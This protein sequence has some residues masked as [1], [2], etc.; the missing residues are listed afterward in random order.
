MIQKLEYD[1]VKEKVQSYAM[2]YLGRRHAAGME[3]QQDMKRIQRLLEE[4]QEARAVIAHGASVPIPSLEGLE[5]IMDLLGKGYSLDVAE[6]TCIAQFLESTQ[7]LKKFMIKRLPVAPRVSGYAQALETLDGLLDEIRRCLR[8]GFVVDSASRQLGKIRKEIGVV[9]ERLK[10]RLESIMQKY[11]NYL[12]ESVVSLRGDRYVIPIKRAYKKQV[13]GSVLDESASGQTVFV[14][15]AGVSGLQQELAL[16]R[17]EETLEITRILS[18]LTGLV[19]DNQWALEGNLRVVGDYDFLFAKAKYGN[20]IG[21]ISVPLNDVGRVDIRG[22]RHPLLGSQAVPLNFSIGQSYRALLITGPNTGGK[23]VSLKTVGLLSLMAQSGLLVPVEE[24]STFTVFSDILVDVGDGQSI[25]QSL[26]TF[27]AHIRNVIDILAAAGG[28]TLVLLD[29]L[30]SGTDPGEGIALSIAVLEELYRRKATIVATT[31]FNEI[32]DFAAHT[33]GFQNARME[34]DLETLQPL[35][36]LR[37]GE[38]GSSYAFV[39]AQKL[40]FPESLILRSRQIAKEKPLFDGNEESSPRLRA[41]ENAP[42]PICLTEDHSLRKHEDVRVS[43]GSPAVDTSREQE[44]LSRGV[45]IGDRVWIH[46][47]K[48]SG[49]VHSAP[50][51]RGNV[52]VL[53]QKQKMTFNLKRIAPYLSR[54]QLYPDDY[55]LDIVLESKDVRK[56]RKIMAKRHVTGLAIEHPP[57]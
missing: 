29:E 34:F 15:P 45:Q 52:D 22:G 41:T 3:P 2:S 44:E 18:S 25:E 37:L 12:Q 31:H 26:S 36:R 33:A 57:E 13:E 28:K 35:Y 4:A 19:E 6:L 39:I 43:A 47:L 20:E 53:V 16:L 55:D 42:Q 11:R 24:G 32:K 30:A 21:G 46:P 49:I 9:E 51:A 7:Q 23:T 54:E 50:D 14:E 17:S 56:K 8:N 38:A 10:K 1:K 27:S 48:R 5:K 40:G